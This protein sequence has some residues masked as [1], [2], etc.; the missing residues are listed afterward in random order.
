MGIIKNRSAF[1]LSLVGLLATAPYVL[2]CAITWVH[3][4]FRPSP[5]GAEAYVIY[6]VSLPVSWLVERISFLPWTPLHALQ[7]WILPISMLGC[8][9]SYYFIG[10]FLEL[11]FTSRERLVPKIKAALYWCSAPTFS[12]ILAAVWWRLWLYHG[13]F[14]IPRGLYLHLHTCLEGSGYDATFIGMWIILC[15]I[16]FVGL[17]L[18]RIYCRVRET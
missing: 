15:A 13:F 3:L 16:G 8:L 1:G 18:V 11:Y 17:V 10:R 7:I 4:Y 12:F 9:Y 2:L 6:F 14:C 5:E